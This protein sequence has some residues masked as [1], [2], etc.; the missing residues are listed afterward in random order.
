MKD[1]Q[2]IDLIFT[3]AIRPSIGEEWHVAKPRIIARL[4]AEVDAALLDRYVDDS[5]SPSIN[6]NSYGV[7]PGFFAHRDTKRLLEFY[8]SR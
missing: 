3:R 6:L 1:Q 2:A 4:P 7:E 5:A 8:R